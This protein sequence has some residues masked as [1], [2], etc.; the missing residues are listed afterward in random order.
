[1]KN[2]LNASQMLTSSTPAPCTNSPDEIPKGAV[3]A[4]IATD[5]IDT[6]PVVNAQAKY[7]GEVAHL[8]AIVPDGQIAYVVVSSGGVLGVGNKL[9]AIPWSALVFD[10]DNECFVLNTT[11]ET[12]EKAP[13]FDKDNWPVM[14]DT[15]WGTQIH[16]YY[17]QRNYWHQPNNSQAQTS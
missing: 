11:E 15:T 1:M 5:A 6:C 4:I 9:H 12:L 3:T 7:I 14:T 8:M 13:A 17:G 16:D 10:E 2:T